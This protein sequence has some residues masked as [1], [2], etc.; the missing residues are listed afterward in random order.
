MGIIVVMELPGATP[1][2]YDRVNEV[3]GIHG[4]D[5][6]PEGLI[7]HIAG[8]TDDGMLIVDVWDSEES[9]DRFF[10]DER[11]GKAI[12][13]T[14]VQPREPRLV[15]VHNMI[16]EGA[17]T[18]VGILM[19]FE[20]DELGPSDYDR[21]V[22][23]LNAHQD[24]GRNHPA[25][26]HVAGRTDGGGI[27]VVDVWESAESWGQFAEAEIAPRAQAAGLGPIEPTLIP[28]HN[29]IRGTGGDGS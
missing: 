25:V 6:A 23:D 9:F 18:D 1:A 15:P 14:G 3:M 8:V 20:S 13:E 4:D 28:V 27:L 12:E 10:A 29:R 2:D 26:S 19:M 16:E 7:S 17:G 22:A 5:N 24:G 11:V 21:M